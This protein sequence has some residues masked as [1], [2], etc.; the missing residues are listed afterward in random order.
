[1]ETVEEYR[2]KIT[3][4]NNLIM[5]AIE[6]M[7]YTNLGQFAKCEGIALGGL[8]D[9]IN[10]KKS[11]IGV[12]GE[13]SKYAKELMEVLGA[14]PTDLWTEEQLTLTLKKNSEERQLSKEG[15]RIALQST[16]RSLIGLPHKDIE[17]KEAEVVIKDMLDSISPRRAK[18]LSLRFGLGGVEEHTLEETAELFDCTR[19][20]IRQIEAKALRDMRHPSRSDTLKILMRDE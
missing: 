9:L 20:R 7:G 13:F 4:R 16:A 10:L 15:L 19:E 12:E 17:Q 6:E 5:R 1:M 14:C 11:P 2:V 18:I 8:Y 3:V